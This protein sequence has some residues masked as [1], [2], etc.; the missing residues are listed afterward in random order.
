MVLYGLS[1]FGHMVLYIYYELT[2][3]YPNMT[4]I[5][6]LDETSELPHC[7]QTLLKWNHGEHSTLKS[8]KEVFI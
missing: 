4:K 3:V 5:R 7:S 6:M 1:V 8:N 2:H